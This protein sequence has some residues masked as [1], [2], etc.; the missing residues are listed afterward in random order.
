MTIDLDNN[1]I[2]KILTNG[3]VISN[4]V[5]EIIAEKD[6]Y[7]I[8]EY[9][10]LTSTIKQ[11]KPYQ[12]LCFA[13]ANAL[14]KK[15]PPSPLKRLITSLIFFLFILTL[16]L[17]A[18]MTVSGGVVGL[19]DL[20][21]K[22]SNNYLIIGFSA[23]A[24]LVLIS[25]SVFE[26]GPKIEL[27]KIIIAPRNSHRLKKMVDSDDLNIEKFIGISNGWFFKN[28]SYVLLLHYLNWEIDT[29]KENNIY[30]LVIE[31][32]KKHSN[33]RLIFCSDKTDKIFGKND[34]WANELVKNN[35]HFDEI[36]IPKITVSE[37]FNQSKNKNDP[38]F[39][40]KFIYSIKKLNPN[41]FEIENI[42]DNFELIY[43]EFQAKNDFKIE[44]YIQP[45]QS[46]D[47][48]KDNKNSILIDTFFNRY[49]CFNTNT[50]KNKEILL[51]TVLY[52][53]YFFEKPISKKLLEKVLIIFNSPSIRQELKLNSEHILNHL[54][55]EDNNRI[56][57]FVNDKILD[58]LFSG[59]SSLSSVVIDDDKFGLNKKIDQFLIN[60]VI[61]NRNDLFKKLNLKTSY[62]SAYEDYVKFFLFFYDDTNLDFAIA[63][64][65]LLHLNFQ[66]LFFYELYLSSKFSKTPFEKDKTGEFY[67]LSS[68][69][70]QRAWIN[71]LN[72][73]AELSINLF[74]LKIGIETL[75]INPFHSLIQII[76]DSLN[77]IKNIDIS[78]GEIESIISNLSSISFADFNNEFQDFTRKYEEIIARHKFYL[79]VFESEQ[80]KLPA[81]NL[82]KEIEDFLIILLPLIETNFANQIPILEIDKYLEIVTTDFDFIF[83]QILVT[84]HNNYFNNGKEFIKRGN[85]LENEISRIKKKVLEFE[86]LLERLKTKS[87][88]YKEYCYFTLYDAKYY[89]IV[90]LFR[91]C[92]I[93]FN[94]SHFDKEE[95]YSVSKF[96]DVVQR[97]EFIEDYYGIVDA[98]FW[99]CWF[100]TRLS[101]SEL[102]DRKDQIQS[103]VFFNKKTIEDNIKK[104]QTY[105]T[106]NLGYVH[107]DCGLI[108]MG[109]ISDSVIEPPQAYK[110]IHRFLSQK[111]NIP[112]FIQYQLL[113]SLHIICYNGEFMNREILM[114]ESIEIQNRILS[115]FSEFVTPS[116]RNHFQL[117]K[118]GLLFSNVESNKIEI[119]KILAE[120]ENSIDLLTDEEK[121]LFYYRYI[122]YMFHTDNFDSIIDKSYIPNAKRLLKNIKFYYIQFLRNY[123]EDYYPKISAIEIESLRAKYKEKIN[124]YNLYVGKIKEEENKDIKSTI[125]FDTNKEYIKRINSLKKDFETIELTIKNIK[126][127]LPLDELRIELDNFIKEYFWKSKVEGEMHAHKYL[128][129]STSRILAESY[130][131][132]Y[133]IKSEKTVTYYEIALSNYFELKEYIPFLKIC[134]ELKPYYNNHLNRNIFALEEKIEQIIQTTNLKGIPIFSCATETDAERLATL[135]YDFSNPNLITSREDYSFFRNIENKLEKNKEKYKFDKDTTGLRKLFSEFY[136]ELSFGSSD[137][138]LIKSLHNI[139]NYSTEHLETLTFDDIR[140][141][142]TSMKN[143]AKRMTDNL[144]FQEIKIE[145]ENKVETLHKNYKTK[146]MNYFNTSP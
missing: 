123:I 73:N 16:T 60:Y 79:S 71:F 113:S 30:N 135:I 67:L 143:V 3:S 45:S 127:D 19:L 15:N 27:I 37:L 9:N 93:E 110:L 50:D 55:K 63:E 31:L 47:T 90:H 49:N 74:G 116:Q 6:N 89:L 10:T 66:E 94:F 18:L 53:Y 97:F 76:S 75:S 119:E 138:K 98:L 77:K 115:D 56:S 118:I 85:Y 100:E 34:T 139:V 128:I 14:D 109:I 87:L 33:I 39:Y 145:L 64:K 86:N 114:Q 111:K 102:I 24:V 107:F 38:I 21:A 121:G 126:N 136:N 103:L 133:G 124:E 122:E 105:T 69:L 44:N 58:N 35:L 125:S 52:H 5:Q 59:L 40:K 48:L 140:T 130:H 17:I 117:G 81:I 95:R 1:R 120:I 61:V 65:L 8:I 106:D 92:K 36:E 51:F 84:I 72:A 83:L 82:I 129:A 141:I 68:T 137:N 80:Q 43:H 144:D 22:Y 12:K 99:E 91:K 13:I 96:K 2:Y 32:L 112:K 11:D 25:L 42:H 142:E 62:F 4:N 23:C 46:K 70:A 101:L 88:N 57:K 20:L 131:D 29:D 134:L 28:K 54:I 108:Y 132:K 7:I 78:L 41:E 146:I 104:I 26:V